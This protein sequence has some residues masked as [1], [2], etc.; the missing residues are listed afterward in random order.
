MFR[1]PSQPKICLLLTCGF[2]YAWMA[3]PVGLAQQTD[4]GGWKELITPDMEAWRNPYDWGKV[5]VVGDEVHLTANKKFFLVSKEQYSDFI[6]EGEILLPEG[7]ANSGFMVRAHV[8]PNKVY[9][10]QA[11]VDGS[12][13]CWSG[14]L[15]DEGR[16]QWLWPSQSGRTTDK[17]ALE[18]EEESKAF[19]KK[20]E[21][22]SALKRNDWNKY[23]MT[24][25]GDHL[26]FEVNGV[27]ITDY[28]DDM[29]AKGYIGI[30]HHGEEG[31]TYKFRNLRIKVLDK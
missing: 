9:G 14:G 31:Q 20:P 19:F 18:H 11:E 22:S 30:Q 4:E 21:I 7:K 1:F 29:D 8:E 24:C 16:R 17:K 10:Y 12:D 23:R 6:F 25:R 2:V 28:H 15:Y 26:I 3:L 27:V 5:E 13:R